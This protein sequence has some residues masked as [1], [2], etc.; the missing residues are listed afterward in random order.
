M[1]EKKLS[2]TLTDEEAEKLSLMRSMF[3]AGFMAGMG[4]RG[5]PKYDAKDPEVFAKAMSACDEMFEVMNR[6][7]G[8]GWDGV[9][10]MRSLAQILGL[11]EDEPKK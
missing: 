5:C 4:Y 9:K 8:D 11:S 6:D 7:F 10:G 2:S 1:V 3:Q